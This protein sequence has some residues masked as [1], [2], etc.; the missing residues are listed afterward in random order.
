MKKIIVILIL[1]FSV[2][3]GCSVAT[4]KKDLETAV[5]N[6]VQ[7]T[8][9]DADYA[10]DIELGGIGMT[11]KIPVEGNMK[12]K[13][14]NGDIEEGI[15]STNLS[16]FGQTSSTIV[17]IKDGYLYNDTG[18]S[19]I[20][21]VYTSDSSEV[22]PFELTT[23][24]LNVDLIKSIDNFKVVKEGT[25]KK[26]TIVVDEEVITKLLNNNMEEYKEY[27]EEITID[28]FEV[29]LVVS[30]N[31]YIIDSN[32]ILELTSVMEKEEIQLKMDVSIH[33][34]NPGE[35]VIFEYPDFSEFD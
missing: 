19:K 18:T 22:A 34:N 11:L 2:L 9:L 5:S 8:E 21:T 6:T 4:D 25:N 13:L 10:V 17:Y 33:Y 7:L 15:M 14:N 24:F 23:A 32:I 30:S 35:T 12:V 31:K 28:R 16:F 3:T 26:Y 20:K 1:M 29:V 27:F